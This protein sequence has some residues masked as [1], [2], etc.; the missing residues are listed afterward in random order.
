MLRNLFQIN[1]E[2]LDGLVDII[3]I[4]I[5][6][7]FVRL[8]DV[9]RI[10]HC[11]FL[12]ADRGGRFHVIE[13]IARRR[14]GTNDACDNEQQHKGQHRDQNHGTDF[15]ENAQNQRGSA[16]LFFLF[17]WLLQCAGAADCVGHIHENEA[18]FGY[19]SFRCRLGLFTEKNG[20]R[21]IYTDLLYHK[22]A[23]L[24]SLFR[25]L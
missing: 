14:K 10:A 2:S 18:P 12:N 6:A 24:L 13:D 1:R 4:D 25:K 22:I 7:V 23:G 9:R 17:F 20:K 3:D 19:G 11:H 15:F 21:D 5:F 16:A 8:V